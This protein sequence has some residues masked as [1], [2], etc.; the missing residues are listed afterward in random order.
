MT[1]SPSPS[2]WSRRAVLRA[3]G[4]GGAALAVDGWW[5]RLDAQDLSKIR[6]KT[7]GYT[8]SF[9][10]IEWTVAQREQV[11]EGARKYGLKLV[12]L[13]GQ[14]QA[15]KQVRD[16]EDLVTKKVDLIII[17]TWFAEAITPA[18]REVNRAGIPI[19]VLSSDL[20]GGV[21]YTTHIWT[22]SLETG[23][24]VGRAV[25]KALG[26]KGRV[27]QIEGKP[28]SVVNQQR[29]R[30]F[31]EVV[32]PE[33]E[34]KIVAHAIANYERVQA[35]KAMEDILQ[36]HPKIDAVYAHNDDMAL[37]IMQAFREAGRKGE[38][39][40]YGVDGIQV[41]ALQAILDGEMTASW[42][43]LPLGS[44]GVELAV[45]I[46]SGKTLP[47][48]ILLPSPM[49]T[50]GNVLEFYDAGARKRKVAPVKLP[51]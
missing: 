14:N 3:L 38:A 49:I 5:S 27:V 32:E 30:G 13:D 35:L 8:Q 34:I 45:R 11:E 43:Y 25:V 39:R 9:S 4:A 17:A 47:R 28:G 29:G 7:I 42:L 12:Y 50:R 44:E 22:D 18:V 15:A 26:G 23:R 20:V 31:R 37:G 2:G 40:V 24:E 10:T 41:E 46:L 1:Q 51:V 48:Q 36:A 16:I 6:G 21:D 33:K 19:V